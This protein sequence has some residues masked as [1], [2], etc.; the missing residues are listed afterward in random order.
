M[1]P[2]YF[3]G[4]FFGKHKLAPLI[5]PKKTWEGSILGTILATILGSIYYFLVI[6]TGNIFSI[7]LLTLLLSIMG[8]LGDLFFSKLKREN[9]I[10]DFSDLIPGHGGILDRFDSMI[11]ATLVYL[12]FIQYI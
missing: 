8:Q 7:I 3:G 1:H 11:F 4:T 5:S 6:R 10:K 2:E 12:I 9:G